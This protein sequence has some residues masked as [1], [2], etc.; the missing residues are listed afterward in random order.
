N[1]ETALMT[2][3]HTGDARAVKAL[4]IHG[5]AVNAKESSHQQTALMWAVA[6]RH[7]EV[8]AVLLEFGADFRA[9]SLAYPQTVVGEQAQGAGREELNYIVSRGGSTPLLFAARVGDE[10]SAKLLLAKGADV[11]DALA[12][13]TTALILAAY[14]GQGTVGEVLLEK[15]ANPNNADI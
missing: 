13:G 9:R 4:L 14:S 12:D 1:G 3:S 10:E 15:G 11:N 7:P 8:V 6:Q 2:C 5:A